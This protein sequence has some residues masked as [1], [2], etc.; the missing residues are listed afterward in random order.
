MVSELS[1]GVPSASHEFVQAC[2]VAIGEVGISD[3]ADQADAICDCLRRF[4]EASSGERD[5]VV[6]AC[7]VFLLAS[8]F[9]RGGGCRGSTEHSHRRRRA[10]VQAVLDILRRQFADSDLSLGGV[11]RRLSLSQ[12]YLSRAI[13]VETRHSFPI[14]LNLVR[15]LK[16]V[17]MLREESIRIKEI[18]GAVGYQSTGEL[19]RQMRHWFRLTPR[20]FRLL[21]GQA[22]RHKGVHLLD[23]N[24]SSQNRPAPPPA[25]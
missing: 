5:L 14:H 19:D 13:A 18:A 9:L 22:P 10:H 6:P 25:C 4:P 16:A 7:A 17:V 21:L 24:A 11:A 23:W 1:D 15:L 2:Q 8:S 3:N 12:A 20:G